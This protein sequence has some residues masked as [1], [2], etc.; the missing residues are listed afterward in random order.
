[1]THSIQNKLYNGFQSLNAEAK[2]AVGF[3]GNHKVAA[4]GAGIG[5]GAAL[6]TVCLLHGKSF[7]L[8]IALYGVAANVIT[9]VMDS[10]CNISLTEGEKKLYK[11]LAQR[12]NNN[13]ECFTAGFKQGVKETVV[14]IP[15]LATLMAIYAGHAILH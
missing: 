9:H 4:V 2:I 14:F 13:A 11:Q 12:A 5:Y 15:I 3:L 8:S 6:T 1:M 10:A 7:S